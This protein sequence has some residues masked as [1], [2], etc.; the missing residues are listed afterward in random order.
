MAAKQPVN[1]SVSGRVTTSID[2]DTFD[3]LRTVALQLVEMNKNLAE[4]NKQIK[5]IA[6]YYERNEGG[7]Y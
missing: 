2:L 6:D 5:R 1:V 7:R 4:Q 3:A